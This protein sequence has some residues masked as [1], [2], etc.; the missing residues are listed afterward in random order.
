MSC[1]EIEGDERSSPTP[2]ILP[3]WFRYDFLGREPGRLRATEA[4]SERPRR[5]GLYA[6]FSAPLLPRT[7]ERESDKNTG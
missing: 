2:V 1:N 5:S 6:R 7:T 3:A 4:C